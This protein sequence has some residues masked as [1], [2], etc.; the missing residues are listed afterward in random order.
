MPRHG[1][2]DKAGNEEMAGALSSPTHL[3]VQCIGGTQSKASQQ[4]SPHAEPPRHRKG[5]T[6]VE[7]WSRRGKKGKEAA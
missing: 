7:N 3:Q 6:Q 4:G 5:R 2:P 1:P